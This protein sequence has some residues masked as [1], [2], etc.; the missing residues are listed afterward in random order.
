LPAEL[1]PL[2]EVRQVLLRD[3]EAVRRQETRQQTLARLRSKYHARLPSEGAARD[4][5]GQSP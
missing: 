2:E 5:S 4:P 1:P 3:Y